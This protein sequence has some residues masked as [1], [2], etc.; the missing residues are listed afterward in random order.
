M[1]D[2]ETTLLADLIWDHEVEHIYEQVWLDQKATQQIAKNMSVKHPELSEDRKPAV[3]TTDFVVRLRS[4]H[5]EAYSVK[6]STQAGI[7][8]ASNQHDKSTKRVLAKLEIERRYWTERKADWFLVT[9]K[10]LCKVRSQNIYMLLGTQDASAEIGP[11]KW[12]RWSDAA[13]AGLHCSPARPLIEIAQDMKNEFEGRASNFILT[14]KKLCADR[15]LHF[16]LSTP[17]APTM[18]ASKFAHEPCRAAPVPQGA[19]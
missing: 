1:S 18:Q 11:D 19:F 12:L 7:G 2:L 6:P 4:G 5:L 10:D 16:D 3:M 13:F 15:V 8:T 17:F 14:V 9:D